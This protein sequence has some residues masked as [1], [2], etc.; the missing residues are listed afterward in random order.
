MDRYRV[1]LVLDV[2]DEEL[3]VH[4]EERKDRA[5]Y[6]NDPTQWDGSDFF[7]AAD[8]SIIDQQEVELVSVE[9]VEKGVGEDG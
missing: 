5:P 7:N 6:T 4:L 9:L 2:D 3:A 1:V 8:E